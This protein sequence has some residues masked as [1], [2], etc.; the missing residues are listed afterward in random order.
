[1]PG[2]IALI[3]AGTATLDP[4]I[5]ERVSASK[6]LERAATGRQVTELTD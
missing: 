3:C 1:M 5:F 6:G 2:G 4:W